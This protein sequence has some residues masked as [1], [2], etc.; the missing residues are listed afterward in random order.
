[1]NLLSDVNNND[2]LAIFMLFSL[3]LYFNCLLIIV[4]N[5]LLSII[6]VI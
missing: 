5:T 4:I 1:M 2:P 3:I 6:L